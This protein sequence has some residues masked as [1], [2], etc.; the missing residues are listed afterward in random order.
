MID[1]NA[2]RRRI[3]VGRMEEIGIAECGM[4]MFILLFSVVVI[5]QIRFFFVDAVNSC[6]K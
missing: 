5:I 6:S 2:K 3:S 4:I 1:P